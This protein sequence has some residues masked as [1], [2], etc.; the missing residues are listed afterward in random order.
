VPAIRFADTILNIEPIY[1]QAETAAS[2]VLAL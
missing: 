1:L 2:P